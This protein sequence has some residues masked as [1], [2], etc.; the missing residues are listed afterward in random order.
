MSHDADEVKDR[1]RRIIRDRRSGLDKSVLDSCARDISQ[2]L[3]DYITQDLGFDLSTIRLASYMPAS[4]E[5]SSL[6]LCHEILEQGGT[7]MMPQVNGKHLVFRK[8]SGFEAGY[9]KGHFGISEP[10][11]EYPSA[12]ISSADVVIVPGIAYNDEGIRLGQGGGYYDRVWEYLG[13]DSPD[14]KTV[15]IGICYDFQM[16]SSIPVNEKDMVVDVLFEVEA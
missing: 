9:V 10:G 12:D 7:V 16:V 6:P 8:V 14:R 13:G 15:L 1:I 11:D 4:G 5:L 2:D 3:K